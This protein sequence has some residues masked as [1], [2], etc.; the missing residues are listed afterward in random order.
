MELVNL[1]DRD[2][3]RSVRQMHRKNKASRTGARLSRRHGRLFG[4]N[5]KEQEM[6]EEE[7]VREGHGSEP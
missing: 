1:D 6:F 3:D 5:H 4:T 2:M 7:N